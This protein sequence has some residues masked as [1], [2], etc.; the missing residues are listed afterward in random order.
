MANT[1]VVACSI[2]VAA[3]SMQRGV[4]AQVSL[5]PVI[6]HIGDPSRYPAFGNRQQAWRTGKLTEVYFDDPGAIPTLAE[7]GKVA[8]AAVTTAASQ[9][10][11]AIWA[12]EPNS[13]TIV[14]QQGRPAPGAGPAVSFGRF[15]SGAAE[16]TLGGLTSRTNE[17][18]INGQG[19]VAFLA[20]LSG[21]SVDHRN[22]L[23]IWTGPPGL[24]KIIARKD[25]QPP[26]SRARE[27]Y[28]EMSSPLMS[29]A[30]QVLF[31]AQVLDQNR[32]AE[33]GLFGGMKDD[34]RLIA[35]ENRDAIDAPGLQYR[36]F[37][38]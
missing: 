13:T 8:F 1:L 34:I 19:H 2:I 31:M 12:G 27:T 24:L 29:E 9:T 26:S 22:D 23:G 28:G 11:T 25:A 32:H 6:A 18:A 7:S 38:G 14:A 30:G 10:E 15:I 36:F 3:M 5:K 16:R 17:V 20:L 35:R 21:P 37:Y 33:L 4:F